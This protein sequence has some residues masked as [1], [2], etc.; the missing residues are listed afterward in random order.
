MN[1]QYI[2]IIGTTPVVLCENWPWT[3]NSAVR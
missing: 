2:K 3:S 1:G